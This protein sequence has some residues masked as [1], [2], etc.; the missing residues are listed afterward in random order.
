MPVVGRTPHRLPLFPCDIR[1]KRTLQRVPN[2]GLY[3][4]AS[5]NNRDLDALIQLRQHADDL[6]IKQTI[7]ARLR[8]VYLFTVLLILIPLSI[9]SLQQLAAVSSP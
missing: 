8:L 6:D 9:L 3:S 2:H 7:S 4:A 5:P 1:H